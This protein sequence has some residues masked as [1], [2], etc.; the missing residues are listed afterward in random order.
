VRG[1]KLTTHIRLGMRSKNGWSCTS[2][3]PIPLHGVVLRG[4]TGT[5][6]PLP[7]F[8]TVPGTCCR[9]PTAHSYRHTR[10]HYFLAYLTTICQLLRFYNVYRVGLC[11]ETER[12]RIYHFFLNSWFLHGESEAKEQEVEPNWNSIHVT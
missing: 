3:P 6:L 2:T 10:M 4:S 8:G 9:I 11:E 12:L 7:V 1:V 5:I